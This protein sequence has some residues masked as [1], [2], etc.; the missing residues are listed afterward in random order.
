MDILLVYFGLQFT[1]LDRWIAL[2]SMKMNLPLSF[3]L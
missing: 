3:S 1:L 2:T